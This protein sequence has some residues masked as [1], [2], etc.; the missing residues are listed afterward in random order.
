MSEE[1]IKAKTDK[2]D[3]IDLMEVFRKI[4]ANRFLIYKSIVVFF[5]LGLI[6]VFFSPKEYKAEVILVV[7][8]SS[9]TSGMSGLLE[10]FGGM[11][12]LGNLGSGLSEDAIT[13]EL[14]PDIIKSTPFLLDIMNTKLTDSKHDSTLLVSEF[15]DRHTRPNVGQ[16][17]LGN[18]IGLPGK[19]Y[20]LIR[21]RSKD[22]VL[23]TEYI[24][25]K[26][27]K[28][29]S[30]QNYIAGV[31]RKRI[32]AKQGEVINTL[33]IN[34]E[35]QD[36]QLAAQLADSVVKSL[37][38]YII[39]YRTQKAKTDLSFVVQ[40]HSEAEKKYA[41]AQRALAAFK[42]RNQNIVTASGQIVEQNLQSE[43]TLAFNIFSTLSQQLE[44][45]K[46]KVQEKTPVFKVMEPA[47]VPLNKSRPKSSL[48]L[49][50]VIFLGGIIGVGLVLRKIYITNAKKDLL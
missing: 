27:L 3:E 8:S 2:A 10:Q 34:L 20:G 14:Y 42:D 38:S 49:L 36:P 29:S 40:S 44:Q 7:E 41:G 28:L 43:Y 26:P 39:D 4:W 13:P 48:I 45:A 16:F 11:A 32:S 46:M 18:T 17:I 9:S 24:Q 15:L 21:G 6:I 5:L 47:K 12:G 22:V 19:L 35:M 23:S 50:E 1:V 33:I 31:L 30:K 37:T 25:T